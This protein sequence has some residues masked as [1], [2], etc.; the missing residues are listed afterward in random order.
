[1]KYFWWFTLSAD[2]KAPAWISLI[3]AACWGALALWAYHQGM[4]GDLPLCF[5][6]CCLFYRLGW[7]SRGV[8]EDR[9][10]KGR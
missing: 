10:G 7:A 6:L 9:G 8:F 1:M 3:L 5:C 4:R 2:P